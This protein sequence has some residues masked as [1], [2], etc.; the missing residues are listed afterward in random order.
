M[1]DDIV[2]EQDIDD[3]EQEDFDEADFDENSDEQIDDDE[4]RPSKEID[5]LTALKAA[6]VN[7]EEV[8]E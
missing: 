1:A 7:I 6:G 2:T 8:D 4:V 5:I 3:E